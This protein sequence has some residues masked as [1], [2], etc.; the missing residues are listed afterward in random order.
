MGAWD[1]QQ[2]V[3]VEHRVWGVFDRRYLPALLAVVGVALLWAVV[4]PAIDES[5]SK[6]EIP[7]GTTVSLSRGVTFSPAQGWVYDEPPF[8]DAQSV[9]LFADG[10]SFTVQSGR[11]DG[12]SEQLLAQV[13]SH[14][15]DWTTRGDARAFQSGQ[16]F[17]GSATEIHGGDFSGALFAIAHEGTGVTAIAEGPVGAVT[18]HTRDV[19]EMIAGIR[20]D[21]GSARP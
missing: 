7:A 9:K 13:T 17:P 18:R 10:V 19:A 1:L 21:T 20:F 5:I 11:F 6:D 2:R 12:S 15:D 14:D 16:G 8:P 4:M 3:P